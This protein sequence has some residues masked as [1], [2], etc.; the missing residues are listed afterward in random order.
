MTEILDALSA[1]K[2]EYETGYDLSRASSFRIGGLADVAVFPKDERELSFSISEIKKQGIR[3][4]IIGRGSNVLFADEGYRGVLIFTKNMNQMICYG[5]KISAMCGV[6]LSALAIL[7]RDNSLSGLEFAFGIPGSVGGS[8]AMNA[9][10]FGGDM[11]S[12]VVSTRALNAHTGEIISIVGDENK[13]DYRRSIYIEN[14]NLICLSAEFEL[15]MRDAEEIVAIMRQNSTV[16]RDKQP[17]ELPS[18]G[19]FFKRPEGF[20]AGKL[21]ED[22]GLKGFS[23]GGAQVSLKHAGFIVNTGGA[24]ANDVIKLGETVEKIVFEKFGVKL[25]REVKYIV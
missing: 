18:C 16:R 21:I 20:F 17:L 1:L 2:I 8:V 5:T 22:C 13:F 3:F 11:K 24:T 6:S 4:D 9:G 15:K 25:E 19:S 23:V 12:V 7:A 10:A 14:K